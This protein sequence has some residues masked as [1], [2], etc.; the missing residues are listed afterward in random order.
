MAE[1]P[2]QIQDEEEPN[3]VLDLLAAPLRGI[4]GALQSTYGLADYITGDIL[5]DWDTRLLGRSQT[6]AGGMVEGMS[7]FM[8]GFV[9]IF[10]AVSKAGAL[11][12]AGQATTRAAKLLKSSTARSAIA[13]I[14]T[15]FTVFSEQEQRL[16]NL[17]QQFPELQNPVTEFLAADEDDGVMEG[18]FKN[19]LEGLG[20]GLMVD[21]LVRGFKA[22]RK[23]KN[24]RANGGSEDDI[25]RETANELGEDPVA[26]VNQT[27]QDAMPSEDVVTIDGEVFRKVIKEEPFI[28]VTLTGTDFDEL[29]KLETKT[30]KQLGELEEQLDNYRFFRDENNV[31]RTNAPSDLLTKISSLQ[32]RLT[33]IELEKFRQQVN[34]EEVWWLLSEFR[35]LASVVDA[36]ASEDGL[37]LAMLVDAVQKRNLT[38][39]FLEEIKTETAGDVNLEEVY[40]GYLENAKSLLGK[41]DPAKAK[42]LSSTPKTLDEEVDDILVNQGVKEADPEKPQAET[43]EFSLKPQEERKFSTAQAKQDA[44]E[45]AEEWVRTARQGIGDEKGNIGRAK[46]SKQFLSEEDDMGL[47]GAV[48]DAIVRNEPVKPPSTTA[49]DV[50]RSKQLRDDYVA[51]SNTMSSDAKKAYDDIFLKGADETIEN[52]EQSMRFARTFRL[53]L[54]NKVKDVVRVAKKNGLTDVQRKAEVAALAEDV[55]RFQAREQMLARQMGRGLRDVQ[56][57]R[58]GK[59]SVNTIDEIRTGGTEFSEAWMRD[60]KKEWIDKVIDIIQRGGSEEEIMRK[61]LNITEKTRGGKLDIAKEIWINNIL[62]GPPTQVVNL[63]GGA[64]AMTMDVAEQSIGALLAGRPDLAKAA[65]KTAIDMDTLAESWQWGMRSLKE[66]RQFLIPQSNRA[67]DTR[68]QAAFTS[69][70]V[71]IAADSPWYNTVNT[72]AEVLR[73]PS[74]GLSGMDEFMKQLNARRAAKYKATVEAIQAGKTDPTEIAAYVHKRIDKVITEGGELYSQHAVAKEGFIKARQR[75]L[76][77][78]ATIEYVNKYVKDNFDEDASA[79]ADYSKDVAEE[80]TFTKELDPDSLSG[81]FQKLVARNPILSFVIPFIRTPLNILDYSTKRTG[82]GLAISRNHRELAEHYRSGDPMRIAKANGQIA[83]TAAGV[84]TT[85]PIMIQFSDRIT[86]GGPRDHRKRKRLEEGGWQPY[87]IRMPDGSYV[88]YQR[89]DPLATIIGVYADINDMMREGGDIGEPGWEHVL[90]SLILALQRNITNKS[91]LAGIEQFTSAMS[92]ESGKSIQRFIGNLGTGFVPYSGAFR[93]VGQSVAGDIMDQNDMKEIRNIMDKFRQFLP[94]D[95]PI[96]QSGFKLD[97]RRNLLG[98]EKEIEGLFGQRWTNA[99]SPIRYKSAVDDEVM[100]EIAGLDHAFTQP[101]PNFRG[102]IDLTEYRNSKGQSAHDRR[103]E[104]MGQVKINGRT[105]RQELARLIKTREYQRHSPV[106]EAGLPS[107]RV[108]MINRVLTQYRSKGMEQALREFPELQKF[109]RQYTEIRR[110]QRQGVAIE[111][112]IQTLEF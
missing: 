45:M 44:E 11:A 104:L 68:P 51:M 6:M 12:K 106:S 53:I 1:D 41:P 46:E 88:S 30:T 56:F 63:L 79:L 33:S 54:S 109:H 94:V 84:L 43:F 80:V 60:R 38:D 50:A 65:I 93:T 20:L 9:P 5:P 52:L 95:T 14:A 97:S 98:E 90:R 78:E 25:L 40:T 36:G 58:Q 21:G 13:G 71:G 72:V 31:D 42:Q 29:L 18:R 23:G 15:D 19:A 39:E 24:V 7:Q 74:R 96:A 17:V 3:L 85:F 83:T 86:G 99:I 73:Y 103:L 82:F 92:D 100:E 57:F 26:T 59:R 4:E 70:N 87:S 8:T 89:L 22:V 108:Q 28:D 75:E 61:V 102:L 48:H 91:Y 112:L 101:S 76:T 64:L 34:E 67:L 105:L 77:D 107:P 35:N 81:Q 37:R 10:G 2:L 47:I 16:S 27:I 110:K 111:N 62:S 49:D 55:Y 32:K 66:D 69:E